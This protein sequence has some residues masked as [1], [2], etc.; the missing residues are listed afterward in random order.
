MALSQWKGERD[1]ILLAVSKML[2]H[3]RNFFA[4]RRPINPACLP[5]PSGRASCAE[6]GPPAPPHSRCCSGSAVKNDWSASVKAQVHVHT[7]AGRVNPNKTSG[8][9]IL[10]FNRICTFKH[11][12]IV[13][14]WLDRILVH[15]WRPDFI[16]TPRFPTVFFE[17]FWRGEK[18]FSYYALAL[19]SSSHPF[20][21]N[22]LKQD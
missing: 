13:W 20:W 8:G 1:R 14:P 9:H 2:L 4:G 15:F 7:L 16:E 12:A 3:V 11:T 5:D 6:T 18:H 22:S 19:A 10:S 21:V 17:C